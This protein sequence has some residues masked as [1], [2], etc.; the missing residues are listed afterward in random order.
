M[1]KDISEE[2]EKILKGIHDCKPSLSQPPVG[3]ILRDIL[4]YSPEHISVLGSFGLGLQQ[5][6]AVVDLDRPHPDLSNHAIF[7][8]LGSEFGVVVQDLLKIVSTCED[9]SD[10]VLHS[11]NDVFVFAHRKISCTQGLESPL[12][13]KNHIRFVGSREVRDELRRS[14]VNDD[15]TMPDLRSPGLSDFYH[16]QRDNSRYQKDIAEAENRLKHFE[17][18][19]LSSM[20]QKIQDSITS[21]RGE[22]GNESYYGFNKVNI[23][24]VAAILAESMGYEFEYGYYQATRYH[25]EGYNFWYMQVGDDNLSF[26]MDGVVRYCPQQ[27]P[28]QEL[29]SLASDEIKE[30]IDFLEEFPET[31]NCPL[32]DHY[33]VVV[34]GLN[35]PNSWQHRPFRYTSRSGDVLKFPQLGD[36]KDSLNKTLIAGNYLNCALLGERDGHHYFISYWR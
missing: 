35:F 13:D 6:S 29:S 15:I 10:V 1:K 11:L 16:V 17:D 34:P 32:F 25:F 28:Y 7:K 4:E 27:Y 19:G 2:Q 22:S 3:D 26:L 23:K 21:M 5:F 9:L 14:S 8:D 24:A 33:I 36:A 18:M 20:S 30:L 12:V 31:G